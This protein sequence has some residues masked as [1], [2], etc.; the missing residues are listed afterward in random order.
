MTGEE[1]GAGIQERLQVVREQLEESCRKV[2]RSPSEVQLV[3]VTKGRSEGEVREAYAAGA[4]RFGENRAGEALSKMAALA[5]LSPISWEM[6]G[7]VQSRKAKDVAAAF[8]CVHSVD[9]MKLARR[10]SEFAGVAQRKLPILLECNVSGEATKAGWDMAEERAWPE[11]CAALLQVADLPHLEVLGLMTMAPWNSDAERARPVFRR[12][13]RLAAYLESRLPGCWSEL[14]M[15]MTDDYGVAIE[16][17]STI[18]RV[19]R[20]IFEPV[21]LH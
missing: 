17:G 21:I 6:V 3:V 10:L 11:R 13:A 1:S 4:R 2:G 14:S 18:I 5:D 12:L 19:G 7:H 9:R 15:G 8:D 16:E 20:A